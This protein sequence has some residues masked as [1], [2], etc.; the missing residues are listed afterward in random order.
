MLPRA[1]GNDVHAP[2]AET[3]D[4]REGVGSVSCTAAASEGPLFVTTIVKVTFEPGKAVAGPVLVTLRSAP[5][6]TGSVVVELLFPGFVSVV[7][8]VT[9]A[10][11][12]MLPVAPDA[13]AYF[14]VRLVTDP[15]VIAPM[16]HGNEMHPP[17]LTETNLSP[18]PGVSSTTTPVASDGPKFFTSIV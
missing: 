17:P 4:R 3:N 1:Q 18:A 15:A 9:V 7:D 11:F 12:E 14:A 2:D 6:V 16:V 13:T 5:V 8:D 10:V